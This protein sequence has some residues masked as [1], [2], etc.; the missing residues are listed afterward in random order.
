MGYRHIDCARLYGN[1]AEVGTGLARALGEGLCKREELFIVSKVWNNAHSTEATKASLEL[2]LKELGLQYIDLLL[3]HWPID[4]KLGAEMTPRNEAGH[5]IP[6]ESG[7]ASVKICYQ[8]MEAAVD[9]GLI[10]SI[11]ISNFN[12]ADITDLYTYARIKPVANQI[13]IHPY[14]AQESLVAFCREKQIVCPAY[15]P[16]ANPNPGSGD[17]TPLGEPLI[18]DLAKKYNKSAG[19]IV[20][21]WG[22][23]LH[24]VVLPK[25]T[26]PTRIAENIDIFDFA[27]SEEDMAAIKA[28]LSSK[29]KRLVNPAVRP[30][31]AKF[32]PEA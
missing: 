6:D 30:G 10:K 11:G 19:Q 24:G 9:A 5:V 26:T 25:S 18:L 8:A 4:F 28:Q 23:Q 32:F 14:F 7:L 20:L 17:P 2:T 15:C 1:E 13:E 16:L 3:I 27:L 22:L 21:R 29:Q 31:G 12:E